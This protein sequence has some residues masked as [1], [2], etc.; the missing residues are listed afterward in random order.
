MIVIFVGAIV[1]GIEGVE[2]DGTS[3]KFVEERVVLTSVIEVGLREG[4]A[5]EQADQ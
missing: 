5:D 4:E 3:G 1:V 2:V